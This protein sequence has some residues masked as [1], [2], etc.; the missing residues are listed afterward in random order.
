MRAAIIAFLVI[1]VTRLSSIVVVAA[2]QS[3]WPFRQPLRKTGQL[4]KS[5]PRVPALFGRYGELYLAFLKVKYRVGN[6]ALHED[7]LVPAKLKNCFIRAHLGEE[8][9]GIEWIFGGYFQGSYV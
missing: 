6:I 1:A 4:P 7:V 3:G 5:Q 2:R 9:Q 8:G